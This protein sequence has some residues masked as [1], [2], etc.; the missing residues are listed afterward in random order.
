MAKTYIDTVKYIVTANFN[1]DGLVDKPDII[2]AIFGQTEGLIGDEL[3][4][5]ELQKTGKI[6]RIEVNQE[7]KGGKTFGKIIIPSSLDKLET[8]ILAS[9]LE[10]VDKVGPCEAS[11][12]VEKVEDTRSAKRKDI[13]DRAKSLL[14]QMSESDVPETQEI[15]EAVK[16]Q[17]RQEEVEEFGA[18][19][20]PAGPAVKTSPS[21]IVV[22]G[23]ADVLNLL[24]HGIKNSIASGGANVPKA[25][26]EL[27]KEK[28]ITVF[29]DGDRGG[30]I[31]LRGLMDKCTIESVARAPDG[32]E[33]EEL[34]GKEI[35]Q[36]LRKKIPINE[37][38]MREGKPSMKPFQQQRIEEKKE[39]AAAA[40]A[41]SF[42]ASPEDEPK[43]R[44]TLTG[45]TGSLNA[46][47]LDKSLKVVDEVPVRKLMT[48][49]ETKAGVYAIVF[50]GIITNRLTQ[51]ASSKGVAWLAGIKEGKI[52]QR[53]EK[54]RIISAE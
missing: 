21:I 44:E 48:T 43:L 35:L 25:L 52:E 33:V 9:A 36:A 1:I 38:K 16:S 26:I 42:E 6:G 31:I 19:K 15:L 2:G 28:A 37:F 4:L 14:N 5:R 8:I 49:L 3:E 32:K 54:T 24:R 47:L 30:E 27:S 22:E 53:P 17:V 11:I 34:T 29:I 10:V 41:E 45:L 46:M 7:V 20:I 18:E 50:D 23:R 12:K 13:I 39:K 51:L 40:Q